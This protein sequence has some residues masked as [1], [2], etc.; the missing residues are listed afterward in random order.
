MTFSLDYFTLGYPT[1][2]KLLEH[3]LSLAREDPAIHIFMDEVSFEKGAMTTDFMCRLDGALNND[4]HLWVSCMKG[5]HP[6]K[7]RAMESELPYDILELR[8][9]KEYH[10]LSYN[11]MW[12]L[13]II[14]RA[15]RY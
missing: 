1:I 10:T 3:T 2:E 6:A 7:D 14:Y 8:W 12:S 5:R 4:S 9:Q 15:E 13:T 11:S